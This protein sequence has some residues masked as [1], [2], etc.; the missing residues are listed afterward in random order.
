MKKILSL[1]LSLMIASSLAFGIVAYAD[2]DGE[3]QVSEETQQENDT[4]A[5]DEMP[6]ESK[7]DPDSIVQYIILDFKDV[8]NKVE[9]SNII[10]GDDDSVDYVKQL[11]KYGYSQSLEETNIDNQ[12]GVIISTS[13][14]SMDELVSLG[15]GCIEEEGVFGTKTTYIYID[16]NGSTD[17]ENGKLLGVIR[18]NM[19]SRPSYCK[20]AQIIKNTVEKEIIGGENNTFL[21]SVYD[22]NV[23]NVLIFVMVL[24]VLIL[25]IILF[26]IRKKIKKEE[27]KN[28]SDEPI[29][30]YDVPTEDVK[31]PETED[32]TEETSEE[33]RDEKEESEEV[34]EEIKTEEPKEENIEE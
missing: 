22:V 34:S 11:Y 17:S 25:F 19:P 13:E 2:P 31:E 16:A 14:T 20:N 33:V 27:Q 5:E 24:I 9:F 21:F 3:T 15:V 12:R 28:L 26:C 29:T 18:F 10:T 6:D 4:S 8:D 32:V 7:Y 30:K 1:I 23:I